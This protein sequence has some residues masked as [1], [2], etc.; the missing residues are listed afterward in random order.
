MTIYQKI[1]GIQKNLLHKNYLK[2]D[3][4]NLGDLNTMN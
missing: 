4:I 3:I 2:V 1:A